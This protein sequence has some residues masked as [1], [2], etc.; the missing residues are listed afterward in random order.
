MVGFKQWVRV[1]DVGFNHPSKPPKAR[2]LKGA[3]SALVGKSSS[4]SRGSRYGSNCF[5]LTVKKWSLG[6]WVGVHARICVVLAAAGRKHFS[7]WKDMSNVM[8]SE[9]GLNLCA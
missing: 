3:C 9:H 5:A 7:H 2:Q 1:Y 4:N 6:V 8:Q